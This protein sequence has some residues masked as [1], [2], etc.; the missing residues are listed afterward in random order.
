MRIGKPLLMVTTTV[1][2][3][4][5]IYEG[6]RLT[7]SLMWIFS[8]VIALFGAAI[9]WTVL[10]VRRERRGGGTTLPGPSKN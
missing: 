6:Y 7:G 1:G 5:G 8:G 9:A 3:A 2:L 4:A 10:R